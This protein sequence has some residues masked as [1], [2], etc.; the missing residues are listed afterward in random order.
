MIIS[1]IWSTNYWEFLIDLLLTCGSLNV[2]IC[3]Q[4]IWL[5]SLISRCERVPP[6]LYMMSHTMY[7]M[8]HADFN[9]LNAA[10][11]CLMR[12]RLIRIHL[13]MVTSFLVF[14][15]ID[16]LRNISKYWYHPHVS[17]YPNSTKR[18]KVFWCCSSVLIRNERLS[19][20]KQTHFFQ[21]PKRDNLLFSVKPGNIKNKNGT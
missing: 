8:S 4:T 5:I 17:A 18:L 2:Q 15:W 21:V 1:R 13:Y 12:L 14:L 10:V 6:W 16:L 11:C 9:S 19:L 20:K 3:I 7:A